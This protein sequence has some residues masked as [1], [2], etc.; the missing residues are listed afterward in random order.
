MHKRFS[1]WSGL[2]PWSIISYTLN[3]IRLV[4]SNGYAMVPVVYTGWQQGFN[5]P[6]VIVAA[7]GVALAVLVYAIVQWAMFRYRLYEDKLGV[8]QG[9]IFKKTHEIP[10]SKIQNVRLEQPFYFRPMG[11][12]SLVVE[13]AGSKE[14]EAVL[15]A[16]NYRQAIQLKHKLVNP[17]LPTPREGVEAN[18][19]D[20]T[21]AGVTSEGAGKHATQGNNSPNTKSESLVRKG[22][23]PLLLFGLYQNNLFWFVIISGPILGQLDW[24]QLAD[25]HLAQSAWLWYEQA[26]GTNLLYQVLFASLLFISFCLLLSLVS[27]AAS[28]LKYYPYHL[29]RNSSTLHRSG[30][31]IAKQSDALALQRIQ[32]IRFSQPIIARLL[33]LWTVY[34]KQVKGTEV[35]QKSQSHMLVPSMTRRTVSA[36]LKNMQGIEARTT[37]LPKHYHPI[38]FG[39][40]WRRA[41]APIMVPAASTIA[42][43]FTP[44]TE[45]LWLIGVGLSL[46]LY[47]RYRQWGYFLDGSDCWIHTGTLGHSWHLIALNKIQ[48]VA[49]IQT[50]GQRKKG[51]ASLEL[52]LA[53][54][55]LTIPYLP[56]S[57]AREIAERAL[58]MTGRSHQNWI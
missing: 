19:E 14:D 47:L 56:L 2:S 7:V 25:T 8:R 20:G 28:V 22:F 27:M 44:L 39:W 58:A 13:T 12:Y 9:L 10:L 54:G 37:E 15:A 21:Q 5:S 38:H 40:Y 4:I 49:I 3:T 52:G 46:G 36:L 35:E 53:S 6:W 48:H 24:S 57:D 45:L 26:V 41:L 16:V 31:I 42:M 33:K 43:G 17:L 29:S 34:F 51:L 1:L 18:R 30:G 55:T 50:K 23:K 11:L 32:V